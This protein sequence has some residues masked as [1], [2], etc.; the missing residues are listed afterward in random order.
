[1]PASDPTTESNTVTPRKLA[2]QLMEAV[3]DGELSVQKALNKWPVYPNSNDSS[4]NAAFKILFF[5]EADEGLHQTEPFYADAQLQL[6]LEVSLTLKQN[7]DLPPHMISTYA[8]IQL[9]NQFYNQQS[10]WL[11]C[12]CEIQKAIQFFSQLASHIKLLISK[13]SH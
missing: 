7:K 12:Y 2:G 1:M 5:F 6:I 8:Q 13:K 9:P 11:S 3:Y 10:F 4:L